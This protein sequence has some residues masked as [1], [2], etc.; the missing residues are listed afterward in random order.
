[1]VQAVTF[2]ETHLQQPVTIAETAEAVS[3][4]L[5]HF[6][7]IFKAVTHYTPYDYLMRRRI[8]ESARILATGISRITDIAFAYQFN[9]LETFARAFRRV[10]GQTPS[11][12]RQQKQCG[13]RQIMPALTPAHLEHIARCGPWHPTLVKNLDLQLIGAMALGPEPTARPAA[14]DWLTQQL[15]TPVESGYAWICYPSNSSD[16]CAYLAGTLATANTPLPSGL[17]TKTVPALTYVRFEQQSSHN[18]LALLLDYIYHTWMPQSDYRPAA[19]CYLT[20]CIRAP[21]WEIYVPI[22]KAE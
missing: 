7:R 1:M 16:N 21:F 3:Y 14:W 11:Q 4:S 18:D 17:V 6:C 13:Y 5:Y 2:L 10:L 22:E 8:A 9:N 12:W 15:R 20:H 19:S